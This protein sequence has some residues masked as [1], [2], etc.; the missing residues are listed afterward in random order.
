MITGHVNADLEAAVRLKV[1][2]PGGQ[3][4]EVEAV[5]DT[6]FNGFLTLPRS[7]VTGL[8]LVLLGMGRGILADGREEVFEV[9]EATV[10]WD[11]QPRAVEADLADGAALLGMAML[12]QNDLHIRVVSGGPVSITPFP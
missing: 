10:V 12:Q 2:G 8:G 5:I 6:G 1:R 4:Q 3:E 9:Y 7:L 11:G